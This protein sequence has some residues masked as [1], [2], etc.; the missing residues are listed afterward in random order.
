MLTSSF[1]YVLL[2]S[3]FGRLGLVW[4]ETADGSQVERVFLPRAGVSTEASVRSA[5]AE[6]GPATCPPIAALAERMRGFLEGEAVAFDL[7]MVAL[8]RCS[9]F[10]RQVLLAEQ[11]IPRGRVSSYGRI[12]R[13]LGA[14]QAGRAVGSAL[15]HNPFPIIIP[16]HRAVRT[17]GDVGG[18]QGGASMKRALLQME[19]VQFSAAGKVL[20]DSP[21]F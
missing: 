6:A 1:F 2:P 21:Y 12:A 14:P 13:Y 8:Q 3:A 4:Q 17:D 7:D 9:A 11:S 19:G 10:Q 18:F 5:Y 15:A 20:M 16:C